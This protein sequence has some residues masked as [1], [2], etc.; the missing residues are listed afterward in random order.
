MNN[1]KQ[2]A[3]TTFYFVDGAQTNRAAKK[4]VRSHVMKGKNA[5]K[6]FHRRSRLQ[7][8]PPRLNAGERTIILR[9]DLDKSKKEFHYSDEE[10]AELIAIMEFPRNAILTGLPVNITN[11]SM[12]IMNEYL[13]RIMNRMY[14]LNPWLS[15]DEV[16][17]MWLPLIFANQ[18]AYYCNIALMQTCNEIY[19]D[20]GSSSPKALY[21]LSQTFNY[22][23]SLLAGPDAL[24]DST[25]MIV[26]TLISQE[27][28]RKGDGALRVHLDGLQKMIQLRGGLPKL[29]GSTALLLKLCKVDIMLAIQHGEPPLFFRDRMAKVRDLLAHKKI[30]FDGNAAASCPQHDFLEPYLHD[31]L[32]DMMWTTSLLNNGVKLDLIT[33]QEMIFSIGYRLTQFHP[34][35]EER[36]LWQLQASYH[37]GITILTMAV[38]LHAGRRQILDYERL[39][40]RLKEIL[41][42]DLEDYNP[43]L[44][45]WLS[46]LGGI[47]V[48]GGYDEHWLP[49]RIRPIATRLNIR[50]WD[51]AY[52][53][54]SHF[55]W[56]HALHDDPG[57]ALWDQAHTG[58]S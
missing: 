14:R 23:T 16:R 15:M 44:A 47:W 11:F 38:F 12:E 10:H 9:Q 39:D 26:V 55:P 50:S 22:V 18:A 42:S 24:S 49:P 30:D 13:T 52:I 56:I 4:L 58:T 17:R 20:N 7:L 29:E 31:I 8:A 1:L 28:I 43:E 5:G 54:L 6:K 34:S 35:E 45:L 25:I 48:S 46:I 40:H 51:E 21:H 27:L 36:R 3:G 2:M 32:V 41:D 57:H 53:I 19:S 37:I 33:L